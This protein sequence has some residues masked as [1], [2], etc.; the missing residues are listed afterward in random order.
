[1]VYHRHGIFP[2]LRMLRKELDD[3]IQECDKSR[4]PT[5]ELFGVVQARRTSLNLFEPHLT[6]C[7][8]FFHVRSRWF[9]CT[10]PSLSRCVEFFNMKSGWF[11]CTEP[12]LTTSL[13]RKQAPCLLPL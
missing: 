5:E 12:S 8:E 4:R 7:G 6:R 9:N 11:D 3:M 13:Q 2:Q 1:M 10:E